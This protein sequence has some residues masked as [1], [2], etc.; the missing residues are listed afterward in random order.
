MPES[1]KEWRMMRGYSKAAMAELLDMDVRTYE[2]CEN[3][4][5]N[6]KLNSAIKFASVVKAPIAEVFLC[7][8]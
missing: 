3:D 6:F 5:G 8:K 7:L 1:V 2:K 4:P